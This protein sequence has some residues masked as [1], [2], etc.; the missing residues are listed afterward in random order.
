[1]WGDI[2]CV[3]W[4]LRVVLE[5]LAAGWVDCWGMCPGKWVWEF[6]VLESVLGVIGRG[7][8]QSWGYIG[9]RNKLQILNV[10][11]ECLACSVGLGCQQI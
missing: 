10:G 2:D 9:L 1:M 6:W 5:M 8:V 7:L 4:K 3:L 11:D